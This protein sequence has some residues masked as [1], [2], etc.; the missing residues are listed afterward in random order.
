MNTKDK[1][2]KKYLALLKKLDENNIAQSNLGY[3]ELEKPIHH[4]YNIEW[5]LRGDVSRREDAWEYEV[6]LNDYS[7]KAW[8][9]DKTFKVYSKKEKIEKEIKPYIP[10]VHLKTYKSWNPWF[11]KFWKHIPSEDRHTWWGVEKYYK[12]VV[13]KWYFK[14]K[15][16]KHYKTH[17][18]VIDEVLI[19]EEAEI[20]D[21]LYSKEY[22]QF[23][24]SNWLNNVPKSYI[25]GIN[26]SNR[27]YSKQTLRNNIQY[28]DLECEEREYQYHH[29]H[30]ALWSYW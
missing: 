22:R 9:K 2:Y 4:G 16:T 10:A 30:S 26:K 29:R 13:P 18:K 11:Q 12:S 19:Q 21:K 8:C 6:L 1:N 5:V 25:K 3:R 24:Y 28:E 7:K 27:S 20:K 15:I 17:Y 14:T 23:E